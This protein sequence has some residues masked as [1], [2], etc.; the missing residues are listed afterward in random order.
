M[1]LDIVEI[2]LAVED[3]FEIT[4]PDQAAGKI[5]TFGDLCDYVKAH[6]PLARTLSDRAVDEKLRALIVEQ[7]DV[8]P[9]E[10]VREARLI[11]D[12]GAG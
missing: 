11:Q 10:V 1:G 3:R 4:I 8:K 2:V 6:S 12:L 5:L 7:L 9:E